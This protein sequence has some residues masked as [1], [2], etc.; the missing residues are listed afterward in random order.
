MTEKHEKI[1]FSWSCS[2]VFMA[3]RKQLVTRDPAAAA[4][5]G[6]PADFGEEEDDIMDE[7]D[8][9]AAGDDFG[10]DFGDDDFGDDADMGASVRVVKKW[11]PRGFVTKRTPVRRVTPQRRVS[12]ALVAQRARVSA[13]QQARMNRLQRLDPNH[14]SPL[15][16]EI[17]RCPMSQDFVLGT[18]EAVSMSA[19]PTVTFKPEKLSCN[20]PCPGFVSISAIQASNLNGL[21]GSGAA[22][23][24]EFS[25]LAL[26]QQMELP[27]LT[28]AHLLQ[29]VGAYSGITPTGYTATSHFLFTA[30]FIGHA[31]MTG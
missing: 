11:T 22:D 31:K 5:F 15:K 23:A 27:K 4:L 25:P 8:A 14:G 29:I 7:V 18:A 10:D 6:A 12:T 13:V 26:N 21:V 1:S 3:T 24:F 30:T 2:E 9:E 28:P 20:A 19:H 16:I 17:F